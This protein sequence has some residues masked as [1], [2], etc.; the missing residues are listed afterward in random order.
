MKVSAIGVSQTAS[1]CGRQAPGPLT[2][3]GRHHLRARSDLA[4]A[5]Y[6]LPKTLILA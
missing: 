1:R 6:Q 5:E 4:I 3:K 2:S